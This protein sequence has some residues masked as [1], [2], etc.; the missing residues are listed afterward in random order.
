[1]NKGFTQRVTMRLLSF[2]FIG[3]LSASTFASL[4][5]VDSQGT[6][7]PSL[8]PMLKR[9][10]PAVVNIA[11]SG[12]VRIQ[13]NPL[14]NDPFFQ[15]F[16]EMPS[17]PRERKTQSL[18]SGVIVDAEKGYIITNNHVIDKADVIKV[19][20]RSG[21]TYDAEL[22]GTDPDSDVAVIQIKAD[23]LAAVPLGNSDNLNVGD[24]AV[25]IGNPFGLGQTVTSGI[26]SAMERSGL[27]IEGYENF[28]QTDA[29]I[30][31]GNSGGAL[32]NLRGELIGINTAIFSKSGGNIGIGFAI[33][34]NMAY[35]IMQQLIEHGEVKRGRLGAQ[36]QDL[37][38]QLAKAFNIPFRRGAVVSHVDK[39]SPADRAGLKPGDVIIELNGKAVRNANMLRNAMGL[40]RI[41]QSVQMKILRDK[42]VISLTATVAEPD[43]SRESLAGSKLH[44]HLTGTELQNIQPDSKLYG[45]IEGV[46]ITSVEPGSPAAQTGLR[47]G[48][49]ITSA[50]RKNI[51]NISE[52]QSAINSSKTLLINIRRGNGSLFLFLQ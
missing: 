52:L 25:A 50:N 17:Q 18:G 7:L 49:I 44:Q 39:N 26:I 15:H 5:A 35:D 21:E 24:F 31:P 48:D 12:T 23:K 36:A 13:G 30:N 51:K 6:P 11:T 27:G 43:M 41:G 10:T 32:V 1:M 33:P 29:S 2:V 42:K 38:P 37:T 22:I 46:I 47:R 20:L 14:F 8:A 45:R 19:T 3:I 34:V 28:L 4:P 16:F 9:V 40:L